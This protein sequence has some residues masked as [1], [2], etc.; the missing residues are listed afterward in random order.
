MHKDYRK[1]L[2]QVSWAA[3]DNGICDMDHRGNFLAKLVGEH[4]SALARGNSIVFDKL[5]R[6]SSRRRHGLA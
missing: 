5:R 2:T 4:A 3:T 6:M 1:F